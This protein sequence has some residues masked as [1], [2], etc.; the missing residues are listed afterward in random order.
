MDPL[1]DPRAGNLLTPRLALRSWRDGDEAPM[2]AMSTDPEVMRYFP[3]VMTPEEVSA[4]IVRQRSLLAAGKPGLYA[5]D[6]RDD[7]S[8]IGFVGLATQTF[9]APFTPAVEVGWR[10]VGA[11]W[12]HG[13]A[14]EAARAALRHGFEDLGLPE[15][16]SMTAVL[17]ERSIAVMRRLGMHRDPADDF[18]HPRV[19]EG[20][21]VRRHV[22][23]RLRLDEWKAGPAGE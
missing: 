6:R 21:E 11:A 23:Y 10:L 14:T 5:V 2:L 1:T 7:G 9:D 4:F 15:V 20:H 18:D 12:G 3:R 19:P 16:V 22:L 8:F 13:F 17:N